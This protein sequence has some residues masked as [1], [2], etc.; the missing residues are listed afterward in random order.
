[1]KKPAGRP[2]YGLRRPALAASLRRVPGASL[3]EAGGQGKFDIDR[4]RRHPATAM[5]TALTRVP[6]VNRLR[7]AGALAL[8]I[9]VVIFILPL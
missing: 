1:M 5:T 6:S 9:L 4:C 8:T 7:P 3:P 2:S